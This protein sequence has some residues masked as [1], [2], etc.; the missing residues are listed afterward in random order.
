[1]VCATSVVVSSRCV[2]LHV[3]VA[4][5]MKQQTAD[6]DDAAHLRR[7]DGARSRFHA[8]SFRPING[9]AIGDWL[10]EQRRCGTFDRMYECG[11]CRHTVDEMHET[12]SASN[13]QLRGSV[14]ILKA[15]NINTY[16]HGSLRDPCQ[17][18]GLRRNVNQPRCPHVCPLR[19]SI[20]FW[21]TTTNG[22]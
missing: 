19:D 10:L 12:S 14:L 5:A 22:S 8:L 13:P 11:H 9:S 15:I 6:E 1:M 3:V 20:L 16:L 4:G 21:T 18:M 17:D 7:C 2:Q